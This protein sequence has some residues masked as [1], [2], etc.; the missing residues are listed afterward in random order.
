MISNS[1]VNARKACFFIFKSFSQTRYLKINPF[2]FS[3]CGDIK[4]IEKAEHA[5]GNLNKGRVRIIR[6]MT[7]LLELILQVSSFWR[8]SNT[9]KKS[10]YN[11]NVLIHNM[12]HIWKQIKV[13]FFFLYLLLKPDFSLS[14]LDD[15]FN[16]WENRGPQ[17]K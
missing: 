2:Y 7:Y 17:T 8:P 9:M 12:I 16:L 14:I 4:V 10:L 5:F 15:T 1:E 13:N 11:N 6:I 3:F